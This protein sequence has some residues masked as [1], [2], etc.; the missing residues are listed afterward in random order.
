MSRA[1][2]CIDTENILV[3][4]KG[5]MEKRKEGSHNPCRFWVLF[6]WQICSQLVDAD[7]VTLN[8]QTCGRVHFTRVSFVIHELDLI[9]SM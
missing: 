2:K 4:I 3:V 8:T 6:R 1:C 5:W 9:I 7:G